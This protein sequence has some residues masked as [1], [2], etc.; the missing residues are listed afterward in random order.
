MKNPENSYTPGGHLSEQQLLRY[1]ADQLDAAE[2]QQVERH[3]LDCPLCSDA[4]EGL[5]GLE[6]QQAQAAVAELK[7]RLASRLQESQDRPLPL[8][9]RW[10]A[11]AAVLLLAGAAVL[12]LQDSATS[13]DQHLSQ[14]EA[15]APA[16]QPAVEMPL[17]VDSPRTAERN[18]PPALPAPQQPPSPADERMIEE[19]QE[20]APQ[21]DLAYTEEEAIIP[22]PMRREM[23]VME[24]ADRE[25]ELIPT[26]T[27]A[28]SGRTAGVAVTKKEKSGRP[29][30]PKRDSLP[31]TPAALAEQ[32]VAQKAAL[33]P[34]QGAPSAQIRIRGTSSLAS[35]PFKGKVVDASTSE[36]LPGVAV[37]I[38]GTNIGTVTD[39]NGDYTLP[40][41]P[42]D[43]TLSLSF[44]G[45]AEK[46]LVVAAGTSQ[47][48]AAL[49]EDVESLSEVVVTTGHSR[50]PLEPE[51]IAPTAA[52]PLEGMRSFRKWV[53]ENLHYPEAARQAGV[54]GTVTVSFFV[55]ADSSLQHV[56]VVKPLGLGLDE[57]AIRLLKEGPAW[58]P[59]TRNG[60]AIGQQTS[61]KITFKLPK[62]K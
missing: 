10:A 57:E 46:Q 13:V 40:L 33:A 30:S 27:D 12:L 56:Q 51:E 61:V 28:L 17:L 39:I 15:P 8:Y 25:D 20:L 11:A 24:E 48:V 54:E 41:P 49:E 26:V 6:P 60:K 3:L 59:A 44:I 18:T 62:D 43:A 14:Q 47:L 35:T 31:A 53:R 52:R 2:M 19:I 29:A 58:Q 7:E 5:A 23:E 32:S 55:A 38:K 34:E 37:R 36:P 9:W 42:S 45:Y 21:A 50:R 4:L 22:P 1:E 16:D